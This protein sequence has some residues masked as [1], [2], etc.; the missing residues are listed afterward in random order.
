V[1]A[2]RAFEGSEI[3][4]RLT[5]LNL[6]KI[7]LRGAFWAPR[8]IIYVRVLRRIFEL[9]HAQLPLIQAGVLPNSQ[10]PTPGTKALPVMHKPCTY[11]EQ[12]AN[13]L[14]RYVSGPY[15]PTRLFW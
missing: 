5:R 13:P 15:F 6:R 11:L 3:E 4:S 10:P 2:L 8:A 1:L 12:I 7:H 14:I 9:W